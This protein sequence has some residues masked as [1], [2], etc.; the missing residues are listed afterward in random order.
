MDKSSDRPLNV[1]LFVDFDVRSS[2]PL[3]AQC[4]LRKLLDE[5]HHVALFGKES[6]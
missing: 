3:Y 5:G 4:V 2:Y 1:V 6:A